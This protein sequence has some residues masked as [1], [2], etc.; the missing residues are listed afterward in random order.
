MQPQWLTMGCA[1]GSHG[2]VG[3]ADQPVKRPCPACDLGLPWRRDAAQSKSGRACAAPPVATARAFRYSI[4][5]SPFRRHK[6][7]NNAGVARRW[8]PTPI[9]YGGPQAD[10]RST[11]RRKTTFCDLHHIASPTAALNG[12]CR[13]TGGKPIDKGHLSWRAFRLQFLGPPPERCV[14]LCLESLR[15]LERWYLHQPLLPTRWR[16]RWSRT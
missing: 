15:S 7:R 8:P 9:K 13:K 10:F 16:L 5:S 2:G 1:L 4:N 11:G 6:R 14:A 3:T 12:R